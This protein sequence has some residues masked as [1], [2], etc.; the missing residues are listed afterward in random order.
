[1]N[2]CCSRC[3]NT[4]ERAGTRDCMGVLLGGRRDIKAI[5]GGFDE[6]KSQGN[7]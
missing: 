5:K 3:C 4:E 2:L 7:I 1:M 6:N